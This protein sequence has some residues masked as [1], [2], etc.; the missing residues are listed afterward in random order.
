LWGRWF[1]DHPKEHL[2]EN[3]HLLKRKIKKNL[4]YLK[5][6]IGVELVVFLESTSMETFEAELKGYFR[7]EL[8]DLF[9]KN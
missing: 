2:T 1:N 6:V 4:E 5:C 9:R 3:V 7:V 8:G